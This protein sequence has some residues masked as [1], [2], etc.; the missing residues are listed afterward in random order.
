M[1]LK[2]LVLALSLVCLGLVASPARAAQVSLAP[3]NYS[4]ASGE[5]FSVAVHVSQLAAEELTFFDLDVSYDDS[6]LSFQGYDLGAGL[7]SEASDES[8]GNYMGGVVNV[9][10]QAADG[11]D[12]SG[13]ADDF[14]LATLNFSALSA[15]SSS[16]YFTFA[17]LTSQQSTSS[18]DLI[19]FDAQGGEGLQLLASADEVSSVPLPGAVWLLGSGLCGLAWRRK[20]VKL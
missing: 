10:Q 19:S 3:A 20:T 11:E 15:G 5:N 14:V 4:H 12:L 6:L 13:Q 8:W 16:L 9:A 2:N 17:E 1:S 18:G 7:G